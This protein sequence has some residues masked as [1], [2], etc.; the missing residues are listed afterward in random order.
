MTASFI[1][2]GSAASGTP[3]SNHCSSIRRPIDRDKSYVRTS[4]GLHLNVNVKR[5]QTEEVV[6]RKETDERTET[7]RDTVRETKVDIDRT[8]WSVLAR[9]PRAIH[10]ALKS[11]LG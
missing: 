6:V 11:K 3:K 8:V 2:G 1:Q 5:A 4:H 10:E 7:V 9:H